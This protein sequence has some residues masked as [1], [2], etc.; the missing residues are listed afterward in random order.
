MLSAFNNEGFEARLAYLADIF[1]A[2]DDPNK[3]MQGE[4]AT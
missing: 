3:K 2:F 4:E 1:E